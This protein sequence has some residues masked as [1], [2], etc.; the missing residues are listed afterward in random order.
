MALHVINVK[1]ID[2]ELN[3]IAVRL[4]HPAARD[5]IRDVAK[6]HILN[7]DGAALD[8]NFQLYDRRQRRQLDGDPPRFD[9]LPD[10]AKD[11]VNRGE[12][13]YWFDPIQV[14]RRRLWEPTMW[15][16]VDWFNRNRD[17]PTDTNYAQLSFPE[18]ARRASEWRAAIDRLWTENYRA[19]HKAG[20]AE[21]RT[22]GRLWENAEEQDRVA[23][24][25][26]PQIIGTQEAKTEWANGYKAGW[27]AGCRAKP[28]AL[29]G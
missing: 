4:F 13:L 18:A 19:G 23:L 22:D 11:V 1:D 2:R 16:I 17:R 28:P 3:N 5:W 10:W 26:T 14:R 20:F 15:N 24:S 12:T 21:G 6:Q 27:D 8:E 25:K 9:L 7:L 29:P